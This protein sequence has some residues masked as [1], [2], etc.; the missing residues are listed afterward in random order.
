MYI[1]NLQNS[2]AIYDPY[3]AYLWNSKYYKFH[4]NIFHELLFYYSDQ[5]VADK[6][7]KVFYYSDQL[8]ADKT[9]KVQ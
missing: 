4:L 3:G 8:V 9:R 7:R 1:I 6:T 2:Q 5:L